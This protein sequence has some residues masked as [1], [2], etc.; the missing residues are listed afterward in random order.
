[1]YNTIVVSNDKMIVE[2]L[3]FFY[4]NLSFISYLKILDRNDSSRTYYLQICWVSLITF[5][6]K[7]MYLQIWYLKLHWVQ[8]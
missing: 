3:L 8:N 2:N 5:Q 1:M 7:E 6:G 4:M